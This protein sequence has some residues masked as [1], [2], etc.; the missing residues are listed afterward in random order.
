MSVNGLDKI[1]ERILGDAQAEAD[2]ILSQAQEDCARISADYAAQADG[3]REKLS[4]QA[5]QKGL[6]LVARAK[7]ASAMQKRNLLLQQQSD[8]IE[9]V[10]TGAREWILA[11]D[12]EKYTELL[13]GLLASALFDLVDTE[14]KNRAVYGDE[15]ETPA[16]DY[17]VL[18][19][20]K[21]RESCGK[22]VLEGVR[23]KL[24]GKLPQE[25]LER[26]VLSNAAAQVDGGVILRWGDVEC[27]CSFELLFAQLRRELEADVSRALFEVRGQN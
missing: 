26:L 7:S 6:D 15:E 4:L 11:L 12:R 9:S 21:D 25:A 1:T 3:I 16:A 14:A 22:A 24:S 2:R 5:E 27:N 20:K 23:K 18:F 13:T 19:S 17:E 10:F 8:L